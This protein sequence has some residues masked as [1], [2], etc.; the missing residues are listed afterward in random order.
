MQALSRGPC[1]DRRFYLR[2]G[3]FVSNCPMGTQRYRVHSQ[4]RLVIVFF[5]FF[6]VNHTVQFDFFSENNAQYIEIF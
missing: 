6:L 5:V 3:R 1:T 2:K 4:H